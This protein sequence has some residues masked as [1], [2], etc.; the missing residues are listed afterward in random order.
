MMKKYGSKRTPSP[1]AARTP[2]P[3][4]PPAAPAPP[5]PPQ[6]PSPARQKPDPVPLASQPV[7]AA[8][9]A[10]RLG[11]GMRK[12]LS[13]LRSSVPREAA[14][15]KVIGFQGG[16]GVTQLPHKGMGRRTRDLSEGTLQRRYGMQTRDPMD[17]QTRKAKRKRDEGVQVAEQREKSR[18]KALPS[19]ATQWAVEKGRKESEALKARLA[20]I[21]TAATLDKTLGSHGALPSAPVAKRPRPQKPTPGLPLPLFLPDRRRRPR[22]QAGVRT[23]RPVWSLWTLEGP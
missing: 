16:K 21:G 6:Q 4:R 11:G 22:K 19:K 13:Q 9:P 1:A 18:L 3:A 8:A 14:P 12:Q 17:I 15:P 10:R 23:D 20:T 7:Q 2:S 5:R